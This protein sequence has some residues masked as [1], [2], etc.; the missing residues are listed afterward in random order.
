MNVET[1][2]RNSQITKRLLKA[3]QTD[4]VKPVFTPLELA[5]EIVSKIPN[6]KNPDILVVSDTGLLIETKRK[7]KKNITFLCHTEETKKLAEQLNVK[8][9]Y[10]PHSEIRN[11]LKKDL[12]MKFDI[13]VGNPPFQENSAG[14]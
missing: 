5:N 14:K 1:Q 3:Q 8:I 11:W 2:I 4:T 10:V 9:L 7:Y 6:I 12:N 13:I